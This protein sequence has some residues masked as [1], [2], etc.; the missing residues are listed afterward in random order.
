MAKKTPRAKCLETAQLLARISAAD[1][2]GYATCVTCG[3]VHHYKEMDGGHYIAKGSSS[4]WALE[5]ENIHPQCKG[6]NGFKM[7]YGNAESIYTLWMIDNYGRS[8]VDHM[9]ATAKNTKK[10]Y[11]ADYDEFL[12]ETNKL[13]KYHKDRIGED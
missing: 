6:C 13:I 11:K 4:Y 2:N 1:E 7:R 9:H 5:P 10:M 12:S 8:F 3:S